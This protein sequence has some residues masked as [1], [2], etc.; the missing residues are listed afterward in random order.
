MLISLLFASTEI[1]QV[2]TVGEGELCGWQNNNAICKGY[3][4]LWGKCRTSIW[5]KFNCQPATS[6][7][8]CYDNGKCGEQPNGTKRFCTKDRYC[9]SSKY[10]G[11]TY[12]Y[13]N[14]CSIEYSGPDTC[15]I[16]HPPK[17]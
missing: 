15:K 7:T 3:C 11:V 16:D 2:S 4:S 1:A 8:L 5:F 17:E 10:C 6:Q 12:E 9:S 14:T 13:I